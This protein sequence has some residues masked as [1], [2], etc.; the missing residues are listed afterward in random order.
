MNSL[1][2]RQRK[3]LLLSLLFEAIVIGTLVALYYYYPDFEYY[4]LILIGSSSIFVLL[5]FF[6]AIIFNFLYR[7]RRGQAELKAAEVIGNDIS[8]AY[9]YGQIGLAVCDH[10]N[11]V[12]WIN[13]FL[14]SR[15]SNLVDQN[16]LDVF[17]GLFV[18]TDPNYK[19]PDVSLTAESHIYNV[20]LLKEARVYIFKD[21][22]AYENLNAYNQRQSPVVGYIAIDNYYDVQIF[23]GDET[24]FADMLVDLR[25]MISD[26]GES[27]NSMMRRIKDDRYL[28][29][30]TQ[31]SFSHMYEDKFSIVD[32]VRNKFP[33]GFTLSIGVAYGYPDY[34][35]LAELASNALD[36][37]L[38]R[39]GDQTAVQPFSEPIV[40]FGG[41]TELLPSRNR[42]KVRTLS[43]SFLTILGNYKHVIIMGHNNADYDA[44]GACLGVYLLCKYIGTPAHICWEAQQIE[45]KV[46][47][48][49]ESEYSKVE[50]DEMMVNMKEA[51]A[52]ISDETLLVVVDHSSP[53]LSI[54]KELINKFDNIAILDHHRPSNRVFD[55][56]IFN[57]V[58]TS[59]SSASEL[60]TFYIT[61]NQKEIPIDERTATFLLAGICL[62]THFYKEHATN[63]TFEASTQLKNFHA[64][65]A[66][67]TDFLKEELEEYRQK[68]F[69]LNNAETPYYGCLVAVSPDQDIVSPTILSIVA[70]EA[71]SIRGIYVSFCLGR[72]D[73]H[74]VKISARS[75]GSVSVQ[76]LMEKMGGG[77]HLNM[78]ACDF[79]DVT[80]SEVKEKL[81]SILKDYLDDARLSKEV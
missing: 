80:V 15:F 21:V 20:E 1:L 26:F 77:G 6:I 41:K 81:E 50:L 12:I 32:K 22:T 5:D 72:V 66:K 39:G 48:A 16:I 9:T 79:M 38:S 24:K 49:V 47:M 54:F 59:A 34:A 62:D 33:S 74:K 61:Y 69:I 8:E 3:W 57:G 40:Y 23:V 68:I 42:V 71:L 53:D 76:L 2:T 51:E 44:I 64:D 30:T 56:P 19:K 14:G 60:L 67:V 35:K 17:P 78:A 45:D 70:N 29:I 37:A 75:D 65:S 52:L 13:D 10:E 43:N 27:T 7:S 36:V 25:K 73:E 63:N 55:D 46:R 58:D 18:L 4:F 28:F 11:N 31:E